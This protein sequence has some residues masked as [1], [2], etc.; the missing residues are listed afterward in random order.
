MKK[1]K[2]I[3]SAIFLVIFITGM[4]YAYTVIDNN[5]RGFYNS[6]IGTTLDLTNPI[7][8]NQ[9]NDTHLFPG[10]DQSTGDPIIDPISIEPNLSSAIDN[11]G[12]AILGNWLSDPTNLNPYWFGLQTI[13]LSWAINTETAIIYAF[14]AGVGL[15]NV[16]GS[17]GVDNGL[18]VWLDGVYISGATRPEGTFPGEHI[19]NF[20]A[21]SAGT[22]YLQILR[23]DHGEVTGFDTEVTGS[24][25]PVPGS[26]ILLSSGL[27]NL[28][29]LRRKKICN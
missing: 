23:E 28:L 18:Y 27:F 2:L 9:G 10:P 5:S 19:M 17:F 13:P 22:H 11:N 20:G 26:I 15:Q 25:V 6:N 16:V 24:P 12:R 3:I 14:D 4:S 29:L 1:G 7:K 21:L 8:D